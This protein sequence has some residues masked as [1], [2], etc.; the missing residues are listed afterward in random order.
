MAILMLMLLG[1][2]SNDHPIGIY[3]LTTQVV[4]HRRVKPPLN[5]KN[6]NK[7]VHN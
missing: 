6:Y 7:C 1:K 4:D 5:S 3:N 2:Q